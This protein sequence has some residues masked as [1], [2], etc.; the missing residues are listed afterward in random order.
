MPSASPGPVPR[1]RASQS[2]WAAR[3]AARSS[4][5]AVSPQ[6]SAASSSSATASSSS[7]MARV[8]AATGLF[9]SWAMPAARVPSEASVER[10]PALTIMSWARSASTGMTSSETLGVRTSICRK[11]SRS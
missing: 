5:V 1:A 7:P 4:A 8:T 10:R 11:A 9:S 6:V 3:T 2:R